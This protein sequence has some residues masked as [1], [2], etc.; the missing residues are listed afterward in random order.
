MCIIKINSCMLPS[1]ERKKTVFTNRIQTQSQFRLFY[2]R[3]ALATDSK[4]RERHRFLGVAA[5]IVSATRRKKSKQKPYRTPVNGVVPICTN[6]NFNQLTVLG[7]AALIFGK[8]RGRNGDRPPK[9]ITITF[10]ASR[11]FPSRF[12]N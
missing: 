8:E 2:A 10:A 11:A 4:R 6:Q 9:I 12:D 1:I 5:I 7:R 3:N